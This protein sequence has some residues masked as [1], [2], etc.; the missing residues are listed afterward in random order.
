MRRT[1]SDDEGSSGWLEQA[2][3]FIDTH[4]RAARAAPWV[5]GGLGL[6]LVYTGSRGKVRH[7]ILCT[8][9]CV[10]VQF[11]Q[12]TSLAD[13][14]AHVYAQNT[15]LCG[16][17]SRAEWNSVWVWHVPIGRRVLRWRHVPPGTAPPVHV[18]VLLDP[19]P[20]E[21]CPCDQLL[22][23]KFAGVAIGKPAEA[24]VWLANALLG[25][26]VWFEPLCVSS[27]VKAMECVVYS[28]GKVCVCVCVCRGYDNH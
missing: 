7:V 14:P 20:S 2:S 11:K 28:Q 6:L 21:S 26:R 9:L 15:R 25:R 8:S 18:P 16:V 5:L 19:I 23:V 13:V 17:V 10:P 12:F 3:N 1:M 4:L 22:R 27:S 24:E